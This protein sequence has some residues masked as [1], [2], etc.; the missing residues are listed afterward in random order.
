LDNIFKKNI[1]VEQMGEFIG[2]TKA[3]TCGFKLLEVIFG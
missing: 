1:V 3:E 2:G